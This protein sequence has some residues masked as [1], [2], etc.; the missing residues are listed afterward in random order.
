MKV[1]T[2]SYLK[3]HF[4]KTVE[5]ALQGEYTDTW[6]GAVQ[7]VIDKEWSLQFTKKNCLANFQL[8]L[9]SI[10]I[11]NE[12]LIVCYEYCDQM[13]CG[14]LINNGKLIEFMENCGLILQSL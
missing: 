5:L 12:L 6:Y 13:C 10:I 9:Q 1:E 7:F 2:D 3:E 8:F 4:G 14:A 11:K